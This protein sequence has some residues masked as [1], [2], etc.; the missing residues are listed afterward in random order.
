[1]LNDLTIVV[2]SYNHEKYISKLLNSISGV[3]RFDVKVIIIDDASTDRS[4]YLIQKFSNENLEK[5]NNIQIIIKEK[6]SGLVNSLHQALSLCTTKYI[7]TIASDD[8]FHTESL[9]QAYSIVHDSNDKFCIF[10]AENIFNNS[11][12][13]SVYSNKHSIFFQHLSVDERSKLIFYNHPAPILLQSTIFDVSLL[14]EIKA[15]EDA[16]SFDD[17]PIFIKIFGI[18]KISKFSFYPNIILT[19]YYHHQTNTYKNYKKMYSMFVDVYDNLCPKDIYDKARSQI[20]WLYLFRSIKNVDISSII[21]LLKK[22][23]LKNLKY[24]PYFL[25]KRNKNEL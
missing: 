4:K 12:H 17:Y 19:E 10:G 3:L 2:P 16:L 20:W 7:F 21:F 13:T 14:K 6:N 8:N 11:N 24:L 23:K 22:L 25:F 5:S 15:F 18:Y 9:V 1:M